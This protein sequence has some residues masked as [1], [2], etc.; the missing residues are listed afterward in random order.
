VPCRSNCHGRWR[1]R[2][3]E[4]SAA[5]DC[6]GCSLRDMKYGCLQPVLD[7]N[8]ACPLLILPHSGDGKGPGVQQLDRYGRRGVKALLAAL[9]QF[10]APLPTANFG[11]QEGLDDGQAESRDLP[12]RRLEIRDNAA[13]I[14]LESNCMVATSR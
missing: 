11:K 4:L 3:G 1:K 9:I 13:T 7:R 2:E 10:V 5:R 12:G 14:R 6:G 8:S